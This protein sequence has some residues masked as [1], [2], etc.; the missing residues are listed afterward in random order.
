MYGSGIISSQRE[1]THIVQ[2]RP[3]IQPFDLG[4]V[5]KTPVKVDEL[6]RVLYIIED[7]NQIYAAMEQAEKLAIRQ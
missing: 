6:Q 4:Q 5:L 2:G 3:E 1:S 7:F